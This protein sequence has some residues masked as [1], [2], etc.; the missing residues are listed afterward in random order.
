MKRMKRAVVFASAVGTDRKAARPVRRSRFVRQLDL[1]PP[2]V[3][4]EPVA[5]LLEQPAAAV[6]DDA[7]LNAAERFPVRPVLTELEQVRADPLP[8]AAGWTQASSST[9]ATS[10]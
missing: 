1:H 4:D 6:I 7:R 3:A 5:S 9:L 2:E 8:R 10:P